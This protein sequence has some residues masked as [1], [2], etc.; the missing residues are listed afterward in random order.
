M[1][2]GVAAFAAT[3][4]F[5]R[6]DRQL[7]TYTYTLGLIGVV[8]LLLPVVPGI[9]YEINGAR[10]WAAIGP[11]HVPAGGVRQ[12]L[13]RRVPGGLPRGQAR[14]PRERAWDGSGCRAPRTSGRCSLAWGASLAVLFLERDMGASLLFF[15]VFVVMLWIA[16]GRAG[17]LWLGL[18]LFVVGAWLGYLAFDHV[19]TRVDYLAPRARPRSGHGPG[20][21]PAGAGMVRAWRPAASWAPARPGFAHADPVRGQR[22][23]LRG[24]RRGTGHDRRRS[25]CCCCTWSWIA[26]GLRVAM[27][28]V[29]AFGKLLATGLTTIIAL[30]TFAIVAGVTRLIP[31]TGVPLPLVSYGGSSR[32]ATF[33]MLALLVR[34]SAGPSG[35]AAWIGASAGWASGSWRCS[36]LLFAQLA[37]VQVFAADDIKGQAANARRQIIAE[38]KVERGPILTAAPSSAVWPR[39]CR[40][41]SGGPSCCSE[42]LYPDGELYA[43]LTGYYSRIYGR[44]GLEQAA[45]PYLSGDAPE[46][47]ISTFTDLIL[48]RTKKG[49]A[50]R[51]HD[52]RDLQAAAAQALG[53]Q[54]GAVVA[55]DPRDRRRAGARTRTLPTTPTRSR[56]GP[57]QSIVDAWDAINADPDKP[58]VSRAKD[59]L[60]LPGSTGKLITA[61]AALENGV[62]PGVGMGQPPVPRP[63]ADARTRSRTSAT[64]SATAVRRR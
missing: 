38:Y 55:V 18:I 12:D 4:W 40:T 22:L 6:D 32:V 41:R 21:L 44:A 47:A 58:L 52:R 57:T 49:G 59:E 19:Q 34:V 30:Q 50:D 37:Y 33:I 27:E 2:V 13:H 56:T 20:L 54:P 36:R 14:A 8:L 35:A 46:L 25:R 39:A 45:N 10:L 23:H 26:R 63:A 31:L 62:R 28:R 15:G 60:F 64:R 3:L 51:H 1:I 53:D 24:V 42:R 48:G 11:D 43:D 16:S 61:S 29:D 17:Y 7:N 5:V 9:G